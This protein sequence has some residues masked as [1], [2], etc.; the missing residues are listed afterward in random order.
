MHKLLFTG[1]IRK[2]KT[3]V[4]TFLGTKI[5]DIADFGGFYLF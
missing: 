5:K 4:F 2:A 3:S 1:F